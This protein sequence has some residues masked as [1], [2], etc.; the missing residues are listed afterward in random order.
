M[1]IAIVEDERAS[2]D[3]LCGYIARYSAQKQLVIE[4]V[5]FDNPVEFLEKYRGDFD[6]VFMDI[7]MPLMDGMECAG[8]LREMDEHVVL[9]FITS[10]AQYAIRGYEVGALD[11]ILKPVSYGEF[12]LKLDRITRILRR[13]VEATVLIRG[14]SAVHKVAVQDLSYVEVYNHMLVYHAGDAQYEAYGR[15][16]DVEGDARFTRFIRVSTSH[17]VNCDHIS[18][19]GDDYVEVHGS[20]L[21][22]SR[23]RRKDCQGRMAAILGGM[24]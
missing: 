8:H 9:C 5:A 20:R 21:P 7:V 1:R 17:L 22:L 24:A 15:L 6:V 2:I 23:R 3:K 13:R 10:M 14:K 16:S 11:F 12:S 18:S 4:S 19:F